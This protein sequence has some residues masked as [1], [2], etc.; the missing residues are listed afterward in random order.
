MNKVTVLIR[1]NGPQSPRV[2]GV[3]TSKDKLEE[4]YDKEW[5]NLPMK[6]FFNFVEIDVGVGDLLDLLLHS[7]LSSLMKID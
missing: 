5:S 7:G 2:V 3:A 4:L 1:T 6:Q